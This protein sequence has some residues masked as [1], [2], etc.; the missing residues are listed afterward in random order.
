MISYVAAAKCIKRRGLMISHNHA[1]SKPPELDNVPASE[2][3]KTKIHFPTDKVSSSPTRYVGTISR[4][5]LGHQ[6]Q[7]HLRCN[8]LIPRQA[9][10]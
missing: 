8:V 2:V 7:P 9:I 6:K 10:W 4:Y 3:V 1:P 5:A